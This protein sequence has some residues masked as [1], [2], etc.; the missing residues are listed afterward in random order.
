MKIGS[1]SKVDKW[2]EEEEA[3]NLRGWERRRGRPPLRK[4]NCDISGPI[5]PPYQSSLSP[6]PFH[7]YSPQ[8]IA[9]DRRKDV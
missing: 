8:G 7:K 1:G 2:P 3:V 5:R 9:E 4:R 6:F